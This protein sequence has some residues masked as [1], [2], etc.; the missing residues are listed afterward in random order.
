EGDL[1]AST[2]GDTFDGLWPALAVFGKEL[3]IRLAGL[4][5]VDEALAV[6]GDGDRTEVTKVVAAALSEL[7]QMSEAWHILQHG[8][9]GHDAHRRCIGQPLH[10]QLSCEDGRQELA[11]GELDRQYHAVRR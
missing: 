11:D 8:R 2:L 5:G 4:S 10:R 1:T 3:A 7:A 9:H 6:I